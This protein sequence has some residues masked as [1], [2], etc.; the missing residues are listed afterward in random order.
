MQALLTPTSYMLTTACHC[1]TE[2][3]SAMG[4]G[5]TRDA[6]AIAILGT[7]TPGMT[8]GCSHVTWRQPDLLSP[9]NLQGGHAHMQPSH[10][11]KQCG[12]AVTDLGSNLGASPMLD[13]RG[14][15]RTHISL[16]ALLEQPLP[17]LFHNPSHPAWHIINQLVDGGLINGSPSPLNT[18]AP[19]IRRCGP[20][21]R[22]G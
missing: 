18:A 17:L 14:D 6:V 20:R 13:T 21:A 9:Y 4:C 16:C 7:C 8:P 3:A 11:T 10:N 2:S 12:T 15:A 5:F 19:A 1:P 22:H